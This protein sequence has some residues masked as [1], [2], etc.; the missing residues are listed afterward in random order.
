MATNNKRT[1]TEEKKVTAPPVKPQ[2]SVYTAQELAAAH[3]TFGTSYAIVAAS[4]RL[5]GKEK[6]TITEAKQII[7]TF[8]HKEVK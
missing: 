5:A 1:V 2:E 4:L 3:N 8:K 6:A 7:E